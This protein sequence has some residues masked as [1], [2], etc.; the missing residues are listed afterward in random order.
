MSDVAAT[1]RRSSVSHANARLS[2][3]VRLLAARRVEQGHKPGEVA[4]QLG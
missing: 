3:Y 2:Q 1:N 4:K